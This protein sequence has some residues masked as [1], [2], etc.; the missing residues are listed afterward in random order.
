MQH[1]SWWYSLEWVGDTEISHTSCQIYHFWKALA[2]NNQGHKKTGMSKLI[3]PYPQIKWRRGCDVIFLITRLQLTFDSSN[4]FS[5][6]LIFTIGYLWN[7]CPIT[8]T[9]TISETFRFSFCKL[10]PTTQIFFGLSSI[11]RHQNQT[12]VMNARRLF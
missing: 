6:L 10:Q 7:Y 8:R 1:S 9:F 4:E 3:A 2:S 12:K 11:L 5:V